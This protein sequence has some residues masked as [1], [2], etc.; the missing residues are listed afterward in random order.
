MKPKL[1]GFAALAVLSLALAGCPKDE[2]SAAE[3]R[4]AEGAGTHDEHADG[5]EGHG[6]EHGEGAHEDLVELTDAAVK[7]AR[8]QVGK[9][10][11]KALQQTV[12]AP[13]SLTLAQNGTAR[14]AARVPGRIA[15]LHVKPGDEVKERQVLAIIES[16]AVGTLRA[17]YLAAATKARVARGNYEREQRLFERGISS[18]REMSQAEEAW[19]AAR[20]D[21]EAADDKLHTLGLT[22]DEIRKLVASSSHEGAR[23]PLRSPIAGTVL[24]VN[25]APGESIEPTANI[26]TVGQLDELWALLQV[27]EGAA[28]HVQK[29]QQVTFTLQ[30]APDQ[31]FQ[32]VV[33]YVGAV[34]DPRTRTTQVRVV[35]PNESGRLKPGMFASGEIAA[36]DG[37]APQ[38]PVVPREAVQAVEGRD[39]VFV[40]SGPNQFKPVPVRVGTTTASQVEIVEGL[41]GDEPVVVNGAFILKSELSKESMGEGHS[42]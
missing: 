2:H 25:A 26:F 32:G 41:Q 8:L 29:G 34:I 12:T 7:S 40:Q 22:E 20:A 28:L 36:G 35:I 33:D 16:P 9:P 42:H 23:F 4:H 15:Q 5:E 6:A 39:V 21:R 24:E 3:E 38:R 31:K 18:E 17:E 11:M 10:E 13:A 19:V 14:V 1:L 27:P 30:A 37:D